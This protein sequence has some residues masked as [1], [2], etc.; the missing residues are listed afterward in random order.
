MYNA[1]SLVF[2][3]RIWKSPATP[4]NQNHNPFSTYKTTK[5]QKCMIHDVSM[6]GAPMMN[7][8]FLGDIYKKMNGIQSLI[9]WQFTFLV[10]KHMSIK[11]L[12]KLS[13]ILG[14]LKVD[15]LA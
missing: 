7:T 13:D 1:I 10:H 12:S 8:V 14:L 4:P 5:T 11:E 3:K 6:L 15:V 2:K 9:R